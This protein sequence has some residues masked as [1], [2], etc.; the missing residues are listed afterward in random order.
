MTKSVLIV[1]T[2]LGGLATG[3]RLA[4]RGYKVTF[5]EKGPQPGGRLNQIR[6][7]GFTF[8]VGPSFFSMPYEFEELVNDCGIP[9]PFE[10]VELDPLYTVHFRGSSQKFSLYKDIDRLSKQFEGIETNFR[11]KFQAYLKGCESLYNDTV[12]IA[13]RQ[14]FDGLGHYL[15]SLVRV[16]PK[17]VP[18]LFANFWQRAC[19][20]F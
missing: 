6:K 18:V 3:L 11:Q 14:N 8:D 2:G 7:D 4:S 13:I 16:N 9:M 17:H 10:F 1:G 5:V 15:Y 20:H 19:R 12:D